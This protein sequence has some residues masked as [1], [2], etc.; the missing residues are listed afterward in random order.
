MPLNGDLDACVQG[1]E[2]GTDVLGSLVTYELP[3]ETRLP[4]A[5][6]GLGVGFWHPQPTPSLSENQTQGL[7]HAEC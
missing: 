4:L 3:I 1:P 5:V 2:V 6:S 7:V